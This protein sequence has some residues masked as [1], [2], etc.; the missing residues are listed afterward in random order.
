MESGADNIK[1][2]SK[3]THKAFTQY[4]RA[5]KEKKYDSFAEFLYSRFDSV[6]AA[7]KHFGTNHNNFQKF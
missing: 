4:L 1:R 3:S 2:L 6:A 7:N 5:D